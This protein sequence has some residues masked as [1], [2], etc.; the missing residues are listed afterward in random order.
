MFQTKPRPANLLFGFFIKH[1][2]IFRNSFRLFDGSLVQM[3]YIHAVNRFL[4]VNSYSPIASFF[5]LKLSLHFDEW[6]ARETNREDKKR[7]YAICHSIAVKFGEINHR[8]YICYSCQFFNHTYFTRSFSSL[9][10]YV[11]W[12]L[13]SKHTVFFIKSSLRYR[14]TIFQ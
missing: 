10:N 7:T 4:L 9:N 12:N 11:P 5:L 13:F 8:S 6:S 14:S 3:I 1:F 2:H